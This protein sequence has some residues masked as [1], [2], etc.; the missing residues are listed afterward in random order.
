[1]IN[2]A[3]KSLQTCRTEVSRAQGSL[4]ACRRKC[5]PTVVTRCWMTARRVKKQASIQG[6]T[7]RIKRSQDS[8]Q[9]CGGW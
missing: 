7:K 8:T 9:L 4:Q 1:M 6:L 3:Q 2:N 5:V